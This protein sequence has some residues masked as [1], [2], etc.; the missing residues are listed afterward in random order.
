MTSKKY[1]Y[2][3]N[4]WKTLLKLAK[5]I[6][7]TSEW[8]MHST[9]SVVNTCMLIVNIFIFW[10]LGGKKLF[11][12][13]TMLSPKTTHDENFNLLFCAIAPQGTLLL[14]NFSHND[15]LQNNFCTLFCRIGPCETG[16]AVPKLQ[17]IIRNIYLQ[18]I[19]IF[20]LKT[21]PFLSFIVMPLNNNNLLV[22]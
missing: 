4:Y 13:T 11:L 21:V 20:V 14:C 17:K 19:H 3:P 12:G 16:W 15:Y 10:W 8:E 2:Q 6:Y 5:S 18:L 7:P 22:C 1:C 9:R